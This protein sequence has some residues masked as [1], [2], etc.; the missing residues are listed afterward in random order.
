M[1]E[2]FDRIGLIG[3]FEDPGIKDTILCLASYL[4][5][6]E[7]RILLEDKT[8]DYLG[9]HDLP[10]AS[11][12]QIATDVDLAIVVGGDGTMLHAARALA[13]RNVP[14]LGINLGR[15][16]YLTDVSPNDMLCSLEQILGYPALKP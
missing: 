16:G 11:L 1:A 15:L 13:E 6:K 4:Q 3:K 7:R 5:D 8:G 9:E 12:S 2:A 14:L 10:T